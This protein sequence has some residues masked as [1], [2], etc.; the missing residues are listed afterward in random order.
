MCQD[1]LFMLHAYA[2]HL[3]FYTMRKIHDSIRNNYDEQ[4]TFIRF[5]LCVKFTVGSARL[6]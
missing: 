4:K 2:I 3:I 1:K 6:K 5:L